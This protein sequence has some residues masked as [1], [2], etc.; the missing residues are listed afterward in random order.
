MSILNQK[1][2]KNYDELRNRILSDEEAKNF[3]NHCNSLDKVIIV[4][5]SASSRLGNFGEYVDNCGCPV[6]RVNYKQIYP[7]Y[8]INYGKRT[9]LIF[10]YFKNKKINLHDINKDLPE[11][12]VFCK[13]GLASKILSSFPHNIDIKGFTTGFVAILYF[14]MFFDKIELL[15]YNTSFSFAKPVEREYVNGIN[16]AFPWHK[17]RFEDSMID[18]FIHRLYK[19]KIIRIEETYTQYLITNKK[20]TIGNN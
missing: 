10:T 15:G 2:L 13:C 19:G 5:S 1:N 8:Y 20:D 12:F 16:H 11:P 18:L 14:M 17:I 9:D 6:V 3:F 7:D 4:G